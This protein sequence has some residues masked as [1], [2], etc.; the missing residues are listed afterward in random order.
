[1]KILSIANQKGGCGK[2]TLAVNIAAAFA[3][4]GSETLLVD[5]D[6]QAHATFA[7]GYNRKSS[8]RKTSYDIFRS[9]FDNVDVPFEDLVIKA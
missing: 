7:L 5:L 1:M 8:E 2:T 6:P 9:H 4:M 3:K